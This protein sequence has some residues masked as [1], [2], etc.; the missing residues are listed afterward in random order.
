MRSCAAPDPGIIRLSSHRQSLGGQGGEY[1]VWKKLIVGLVALSL[2][3]PLQGLGAQGGELRVWHTLDRDSTGIVAD[4]VAEFGASR[5]VPANAEMVEA[6]LLL[7]ALLDLQKRGDPPPDLIFTS[8]DVAEP[9]LMNNLVV[10]TPS[11]GELFLFGLLEALPGLLEEACRDEP[12]D[13]CLWDGVSSALPLQRPDEKAVE[14][15]VA[16]LCD[17]APGLP[18]CKGGELPAAPIVWSFQIAL[19]N[20]QWLAERG[21]EPPQLLDDVLALRSQ[22][23]LQVVRAE[24][25]FLPLPGNVAPDAIVAFPST[26]L[27]ERPQEALE[28]LGAFF[29]ADYA[30]VLSLGLYSLYRSAGS[31]QADLAADF[32]SA[33]ARNTPVKMALVESAGLLPALAPDDLREWGLDRPE[34]RAVLGALAVLTSYAQSVY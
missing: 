20:R 22:Y 6:S 4:A 27:V 16:W 31:Q 8:H 18:G 23:G 29:Q 28:S 15:T 24:R 5:G 30:P 32:A 12:L 19:L 9:L 14:R 25:D 11:G 21:L 13:R 3:L 17:S 2:A 33:T 1:T 7:Q 10:P 34:T 26:L